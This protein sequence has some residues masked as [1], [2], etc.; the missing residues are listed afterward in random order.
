MP[1]LQA[2]NSDREPGNLHLLLLY[3]LLYDR[4]HHAN[5]ANRSS[6]NAH[7]THGRTRTHHN[8]QPQT[9]AKQQPQQLTTTNHN[10][11][12]QQPQQSINHSLFIHSV[13]LSPVA[14]RSPFASHT[15]SLS[16]ILFRSSSQRCST[17]ELK[18]VSVCDT[19]QDARHR[20]NISL[21]DIH[22]IPIYGYFLSAVIAFGCIIVKWHFIVLLS[23]SV[24]TW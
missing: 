14:V 6:N 24:I 17:A 10:N 8:Q 21:Y 22:W 4:P 11:E 20:A 12:P 13:Q 1:Y 19:L 5:R 16:W 9:P 23:D 2:T 3:H 18:V 15:K 7:H